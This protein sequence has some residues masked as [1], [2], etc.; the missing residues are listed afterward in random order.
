MNSLVFQPHIKFEFISSLSYIFFLMLYFF[1]SLFSFALPLPM[2]FGYSDT[3][4][5]LAPLVFHI[6]R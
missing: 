5:L 4:L 1:I 6:F 2:V 3:Y